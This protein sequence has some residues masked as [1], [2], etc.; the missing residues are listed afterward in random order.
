M[1]VYN[2][3]CTVIPAHGAGIGI[4]GH[5]FLPDRTGTGGFMATA[6]WRSQSR[7]RRACPISRSA[8]RVF[9]EFY[10]ITDVGSD[11]RTDNTFKNFIGSGEC[12]MFG[13]GHITDKIG[14]QR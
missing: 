9:F 3:Y 12:K 4:C 5:P 6:N 13:W 7:S 14:T 2:F 8:S 10:H 11:P 1:L